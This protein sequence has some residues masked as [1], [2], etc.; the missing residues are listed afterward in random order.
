MR[1]FYAKA[2]YFTLVAPLIPIACLCWLFEKLN[3]N[4]ALVA[5]E[6]WAHKLAKKVTGV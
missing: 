1:T 4:K 5:W 6:S 3:D 2:I